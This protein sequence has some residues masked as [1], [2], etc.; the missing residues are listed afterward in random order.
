MK[1]IMDY[2][3][4]HRLCVI[5]VASTIIDNT[6][7]TITYVFYF[8]YRRRTVRELSNEKNSHKFQ[9]CNPSPR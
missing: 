4:E 1:Y 9:Y 2:I 5:Y 6:I 7:L 8:F 3:L